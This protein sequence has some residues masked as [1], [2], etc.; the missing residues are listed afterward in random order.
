MRMKKLLTFLTL[1]TL[2]FGVS[3]AGEATFILSGLTTE[4]SMDWN[5]AVIDPI[6]VTAA[7]NSGNQPKYYSNG[8]AVRFYKN[9]TLN[10]ACSSYKIT[11]IALTS[12]DNTL[13][14]FEKANNVGGEYVSSTGTWTGS[15]NS[16]TLNVTASAR[17]TKIVVTY[18]TGGGSSTTSYNLTDDSSN[19]SV[20]LEPQLLKVLHL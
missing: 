6:T 16:V 18:E 9:N 5:G 12:S 13:S 2:F 15:S 19:G 4:T 10:I 8:D 11:R 7:K 14:K 17:L 20:E 1:L 3:W